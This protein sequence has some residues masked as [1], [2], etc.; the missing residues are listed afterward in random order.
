MV[1]RRMR[2]AIFAV[3]SFWYTAWVNA[4]QPDLRGLSNREFSS[5]ELKEFETLNEAWK[6]AGNKEDD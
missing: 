2:M 6:T 3:A 4:G 5:D 1:E